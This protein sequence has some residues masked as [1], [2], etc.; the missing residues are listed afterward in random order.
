MKGFSWWSSSKECTQVRS[1]VQEDPTCHKTTKPVHH[2]QR[3][4]DDNQRV[5]VSQLESLC[6]AV[7]ELNIAK[8]IN[9]LKINKVKWMRMQVW[10]SLTKCGDPRPI[11]DIRKPGCP[12]SQLNSR[13]N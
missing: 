8:I 10:I 12:G 11:T 9:Y 2:N 7:K 13:P 1:L 6:S 3:V 5:C 4:H